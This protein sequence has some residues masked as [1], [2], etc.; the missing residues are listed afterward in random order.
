MKQKL[1][2]ITTGYINVKNALRINRKLYIWHF[3]SLIIHYMA[4]YQSSRNNIKTLPN[5]IKQ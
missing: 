2:N 3:Y 1:E 4:E 5:V